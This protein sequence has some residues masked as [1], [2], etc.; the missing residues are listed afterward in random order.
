[1]SQILMREPAED[2]PDATDAP[3]RKHSIDRPSR[4]AKPAPAR[5]GR[6][7]KRA[8]PSGSRHARPPDTEIIEP[9]ADRPA[10][11]VP[12]GSI[13]SRDRRPSRGGGPRSPSTREPRKSPPPVDRQAPP[14]RPQ[15]RG[16]PVEGSNPTAVATARTHPISRVRYRGADEGD[17][18]VQHR[19]RRRSRHSVEP[20]TWQHDV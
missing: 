8:R 7:A 13:R 10:G 3:R 11:R 20:E 14:E 12:R 2:E 9:V 5:G 6:P 18:R 16:R 15:R 4:A 1:M 17:D 19:T